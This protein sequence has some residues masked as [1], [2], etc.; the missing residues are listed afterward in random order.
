V[1]LTPNGFGIV[2]NANIA[3]ASKER[4]AR[5]VE[6]LLENR[7]GAIAQL[8]AL[9]R[10]NEAW[11]ATEQAQFFRGTMFPDTA[12]AERFP[13]SSEGRWEQYLSL[14][15]ALI[16][17]EE[18]IATH[19]LSNELMDILRSQVQSGQFSSPKHRHICRVLQAVE[20]DGL[21]RDAD[22]IRPDGHRALVQVVELIRQNPE[23]FPEWH[24]SS[25]AELFNPL[26][27]ENKKSSKGYWF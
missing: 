20:V 12:L 14:R 22:D 15:M 21:K 17:M 23:L 16:P 6:A 11:L 10:G 19:Y 3:P 25:T 9:L 5:L 2:N 8:L 1:I 26:V 24:N 13:R 18:H 27:F 4:I 7:D